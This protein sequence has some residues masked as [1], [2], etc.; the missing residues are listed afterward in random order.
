MPTASGVL[1]IGTGGGVQHLR[2]KQLRLDAQPWLQL[3]GGFGIEASFGNAEDI[4]VHRVF[5]RIEIDDRSLREGARNDVGAASEMRGTHAADGEAPDRSG[6]SYRQ[7]GAHQAG[8]YPQD[9]DGGRDRARLIDKAFEPVGQHHVVFDDQAALLAGLKE[10]PPRL[11]MAERAGAL[12]AGDVLARRTEV[13][14]K[15]VD[16][17]D[18]FKRHAEARELSLHERQSIGSPIEVQHK[19]EH[20][21]DKIPPGARIL[22]WQDGTWKPLDRIWS[23]DRRAGRSVRAFSSRSGSAARRRRRPRSLCLRASSCRLP[24]RRSRP[25]A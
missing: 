1:E 3:V 12:H 23:I 18:P 8:F 4:V 5:E 24:W 6:A 20:G 21:P 14:G 25:S 7:P 22:P 9:V 13:A 2:R 10:A 19:D 11:A 15:S 17:L 16:R